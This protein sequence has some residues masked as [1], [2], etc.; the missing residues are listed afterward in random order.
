MRL[1]RM[2]FCVFVRFCQKADFLLQEVALPSLLPSRDET[3]GKILKKRCDPKTQNDIFYKENVLKF[4]K[5]GG[6]SDQGKETIT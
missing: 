5:R 2:G 1:W 3:E 6:A 4:E